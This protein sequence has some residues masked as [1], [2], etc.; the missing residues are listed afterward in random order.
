MPGGGSEGKEGGVEGVWARKVG[1]LVVG[2]YVDMNK[3]KTLHIP[4]ELHKRLS[5]LAEKNKRKIIGQLEI[6]VDKEYGTI[7]D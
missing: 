6:M 3:R 4:I 5:K 7:P 1:E 2:P